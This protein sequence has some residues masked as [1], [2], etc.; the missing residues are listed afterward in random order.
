M[1]KYL[2]LRRTSSETFSSSNT[3]GKVLASESIS[4]DSGY[5]ST[6]PVAYLSL[7]VS[8]GLRVTL[9]FTVIT[10]SDLNFSKTLCT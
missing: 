10:Y 3:N 1:S 8:S 2:Y 4:T 5:I 7:Y 9:P 6:C